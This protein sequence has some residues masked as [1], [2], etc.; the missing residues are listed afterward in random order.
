[1]EGRRGKARESPR[2]EAAGAVQDNEGQ[3]TRAA[4]AGRT[5]RAAGSA[6][7][8]DLPRH[9]LPGRLPRT[10]RPRAEAGQD[11]RGAS[12][13]GQVQGKVIARAAR[14]RVPGRL[15]RRDADHLP[16]GSI[17]GRSA[18]FSLALR[19]AKSFCLT[20]AHREN[21][22]SSSFFAAATAS[23]AWVVG[24]ASAPC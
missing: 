11:D 14:P 13:R 22:P 5:P 15:P 20:S 24:V 23:V 19:S 16:V 12:G 17:A 7:R 10:E 4:W 1:A 21:R 8:R 6:G 2:R 3:E 9:A 18:A